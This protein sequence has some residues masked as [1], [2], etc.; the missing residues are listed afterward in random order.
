MTWIDGMVLLTVAVAF[1]CG[2]RAG[3]VAEFFDF[4][5]LVVAALL[6]G[7]WSGGF[8]SGLPPTWPLSES[9]RHLMAFWFLFILIYGLMRA[10]GW[11]LARYRE[12][13]GS[14]WV[15]GIGGGVVASVKVLAALFVLLYLALF[16]PIDPQ[17]R[18]TLRH[19]PVASAFDAHY[20]PI[21]DAVI[22]MS[23]RVYRFIVRPY[24]SHHRL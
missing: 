11:F 8:A 7:M 16:V 18:D 4:G 2:W 24:M 5:S 10:L 13:P 14:F 1:Y 6:A 9:A 17:V 12:W 22:E 19:S 20:A 15:G 23:P 3:L 21:N